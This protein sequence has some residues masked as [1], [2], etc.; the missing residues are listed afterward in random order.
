MSTVMQELTITLIANTGHLNSHL[1]LLTFQREHLHKPATPTNGTS[2][3]HAIANTSGLAYGWGTNL[4]D[5]ATLPHT[6]G[7]DASP[8][9]STCV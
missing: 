5:A 3:M 1:R 7:P 4:N 9:H 8:K 2:T 6:M